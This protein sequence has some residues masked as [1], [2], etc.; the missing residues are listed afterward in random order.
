MDIEF[1]FAE[2]IRFWHWWI[3]GVGLLVLEMFTAST[4][5][6]WMGAA[7]GVVGLILLIFPEF[8]WE[9][10]VLVFAILSVLTVVAWRYWQRRHPTETADPNL[11]VRGAQY[12]GRVFTVVEPISDGIGKAKVGDSLWRI[13]TGDESSGSAGTRV[14]VTGVEGATL[15]VEIVPS[16]ND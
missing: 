13:S 14:R 16:E 9:Y 4:F 3:L 1:Q 15:T 11:N 8:G 6:I 7:A 10:Q 5:F 2:N 12:V